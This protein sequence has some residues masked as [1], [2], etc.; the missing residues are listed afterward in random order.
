MKMY[1]LHKN[2]RFN[3]DIVY[4]SKI[5]LFITYYNLNDPSSPK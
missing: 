1:Q 5:A 2:L 4:I 3:F